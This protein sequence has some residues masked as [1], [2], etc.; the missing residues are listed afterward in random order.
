M[1]LMQNG[2]GNE[3]RPYGL[4]HS[5]ALK[6]SDEYVGN[7]KVCI[8]DTGYDRSHPDLPS[9]DWV[10]GSSASKKVP[11]CEDGIGHGTHIAGIIGGLGNN[12][13]GVMGVIRNGMLKL[14]IVRVFDDKK[15][16]VWKSRMIAAVEECAKNDSNI[17]SLSIGSSKPTNHVMSVAAVNASGRKAKFSS[18]NDKIDIAAAGVNVYSTLPNNQ[19]G[20]MSGTSYSAPYV[21]GV[22]ALIWS[23]D[24][25][26]SAKDVWDA[27]VTSAND[28]GQPGYDEKF[29]HGTVNA[30]G[31]AKILGYQPPCTDN[32]VNWSLNLFTLSVDCDWFYVNESFCS[33]FGGDDY[34]GT[35][36][37]IGNIACCV[38]NGG[39]RTAA[40][41]ILKACKDD[42][43]W[44][45]SDGERFNCEW[46][47]QKDTRCSKF[48][49]RFRNFGKTASEVCCI[50]KDK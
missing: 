27:L 11:W 18:F 43:D 6:V 21:V 7:R 24:T 5:Q 10:T 45:D 35:N 15:K 8:V 4:L 39:T 9:G 16:W 29:G 38:C 20:F 26:K 28:K 40:D 44:Y 30:L 46:Y 19:Y 50:C 41:N 13:R 25:S 33:W 47:S 36:G 23:F 22:A 42:D 32:P 14:H 31:A 34:I 17:I 2:R 12:G 1:F 48:G 3:V 49:R 37:Q